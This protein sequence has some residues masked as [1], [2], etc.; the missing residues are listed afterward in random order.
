VLLGVY[1][2]LFGGTLLLV[3]A[4]ERLV[5]RRIGGSRRWLGLAR[6]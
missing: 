3:L 4:V 1:M 2:P 6:A 5:L